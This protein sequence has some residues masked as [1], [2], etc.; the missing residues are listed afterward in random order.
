MIVESV[1]LIV[2]GYLLGSISATYLIGRWL[3]N[4]DLRQ[5]GSGTLGGSMVYEHVGRWAVVPVVLWDIGKAMLP[6]GLG[7][8]LGLG[9]MV[10]A[11]AGLAAA[12]G[13]NWSIFLRF[14]GGRGM[15][16]FVGVWLILFPPGVVWMGGLIVVGWLLGDSAPWL[17]LSLLT[18]PLLADLLGGP[19]MVG[20]IL[21]GGPEVVAPL[22][23]AMILITLVKRLEANHRPLPPPGPERRKVILRRAFLDRDIASH[24]EWIHQ[25][26]GGGTQAERGSEE[27]TTAE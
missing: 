3:G 20:P 1:L 18:M 9:E 27:S 5:Y 23:G 6:T 4:I 12:V 7:L 11:A 17:L 2:G 25:Q 14:T 8:W 10:A 21:L 24:E 16:T 19:Q 13:H 22:S 26:P 15:A